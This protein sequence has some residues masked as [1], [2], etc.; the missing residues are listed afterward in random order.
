MNKTRLGIRFGAGL[1]ACALYVV[2]MLVATDVG[3]NLGSGDHLRLGETLPV[4]ASY[5]SDPAL[6]RLSRLDP[7]VGATAQQDAVARPPAASASGPGQSVS[8]NSG[9]STGGSVDLTNEKPGP[10]PKPR[11][12]PKPKPKPS[13]KPKAS[14][15]PKP[16]P[17]PSPKPKPSHD[18][19]DS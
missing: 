16:S 10:T 18:S 4:A 17:K 7:A 9:S 14:P 13:P 19:N 6:A 15:K 8:A 1:A 2:G 3:F 11:P 5:A 12:S